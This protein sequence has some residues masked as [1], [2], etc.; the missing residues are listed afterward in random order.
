MQRELYLLTYCTLYNVQ[1]SFQ[2]AV[3]TVLGEEGQYTCKHHVNKH[4]VIFAFKSTQCNANN[5]K[6]KA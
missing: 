1:T 3:E 2:V 5:S 4:V 6:A